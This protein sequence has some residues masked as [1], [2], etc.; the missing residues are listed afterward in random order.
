MPLCDWLE[1]IT[2]GALWG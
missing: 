2:L 1:G